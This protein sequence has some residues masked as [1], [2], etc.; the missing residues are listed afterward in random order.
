MLLEGGRNWPGVMK[1]DP[2]VFFVSSIHCIAL[3]IFPAELLFYLELVSVQI[4]F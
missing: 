1:V 3:G 4:D 2:V